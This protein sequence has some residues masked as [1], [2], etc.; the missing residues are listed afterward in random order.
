M[1][2]LYYREI[3]LVLFDKRSS[4]GDV[5]KQ[6]KNLNALVA[7]RRVRA[8]T[9]EHVVR[10]AELF[11]D[12]G[13]SQAVHMLCLPVMRAAV[14][15]KSFSGPIRQDVVVDKL[16]AYFCDWSPERSLDAWTADILC[17]LLW[18][19]DSYE[20]VCAVPD[21]YIKVLDTFAANV[22]SLE[23]DMAQSLLELALE[24]PITDRVKEIT[25]LSKRFVEALDAVVKRYPGDTALGCM[26]CVLMERFVELNDGYK[27]LFESH[28]FKVS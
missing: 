25:E 5:I 15:C 6:L 22:N 12:S 10:I 24:L 9:K 19:K 13:R 26:T 2:D 23:L 14:K 20:R 3:E 8:V 16:V 28:G 7:R 1:D 18:Y 17:T 27:V 4:D 11:C 21:L